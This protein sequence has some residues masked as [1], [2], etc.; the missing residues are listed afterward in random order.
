LLDDL[1]TAAGNVPLPQLFSAL[2]CL[3]GLPPGMNSGQVG[4]FVNPGSGVLVLGVLEVAL[5][6]EEGIPLV[7]LVVQVALEP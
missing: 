4:V 7:L 5:V 2:Q 6:G 3:P 1:L